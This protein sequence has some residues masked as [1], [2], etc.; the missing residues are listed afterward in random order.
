M[1][2]D[3]SF[4][5]NVLGYDFKTKE[6]HC[7][8]CNHNRYIDEGPDNHPKCSGCYQR[9]PIDELGIDEDTK[10][11]LCI[12]CNHYRYADQMQIS[13]AISIVRRG[14]RDVDI[15][16]RL[17]LVVVRTQALPQFKLSH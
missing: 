11:Y 4:S 12:H 10:E 6:S 15:C 3:K 14:R 16:T 8:Q 7:F 5:S 1:D 2:A 13:R 17:L 9:F